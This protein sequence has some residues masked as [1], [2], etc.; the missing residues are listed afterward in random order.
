VFRESNWPEL[1][2]TFVDPPLAA[3]V[4][5]RLGLPPVASDAELIAALPS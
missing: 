5:A 3:R 1:A 2:S 4:A